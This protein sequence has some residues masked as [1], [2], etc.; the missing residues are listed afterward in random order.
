M[1]ERFTKDARAAVQGAVEVAERERSESIDTRH[2]VV[3]LASGTGHA[4]AALEACGPS[5]RCGTWPTA[6]R[7]S[8]WSG[9]GRSAGRGRTWR[10]RSA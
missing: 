7:R 3:T 10:T 6:S 4:P 2:L 9:P 8:R 1:F 5:A